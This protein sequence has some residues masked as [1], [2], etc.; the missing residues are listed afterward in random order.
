MSDFNRSIIKRFPHQF[1]LVK[2]MIEMN[3]EDIEATKI[4]IKKLMRVLANS[5]CDSKIL[6]ELKEILEKIGNNPQ[7]LVHYEDIYDEAADALM[8]ANMNSE[9]YNCKCNV[10][11][12]NID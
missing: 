1:I 6:T 4:H 3:L 9:E 8:F 11:K 12:K 2:T 7:L 5:E 10:F